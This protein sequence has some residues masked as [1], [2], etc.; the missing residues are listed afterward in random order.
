MELLDKNILRENLFV[1][2]VE[3]LILL[4]KKTFFKLN[5]SDHFSEIFSPT[6]KLFWREIIFERDSK[7]EN[8][9]L[10]R[11]V[12]VPIGEPLLLPFL[13]QLLIECFS[14]LVVCINIQ[15]PTQ[16]FV[17]SLLSLCNLIILFVVCV[18]YGEERCEVLAPMA[19]FSETL[20]TFR[21][22]ARDLQ[23][24]CRRLSRPPSRGSPTNS[25]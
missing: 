18:L 4:F 8:Y 17:L 19:I 2:F 23:R 25:S 16:Y 22:S 13:L 12:F 1:G 5:P 7:W 21:K 10:H 20:R 6:K 14:H 24:R 15:R 3:F 11:S 9:I